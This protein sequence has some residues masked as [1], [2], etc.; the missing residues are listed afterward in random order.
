MVPHLLPDEAQL[1][2][3][4]SDLPLQLLSYVDEPQLY[5]ATLQVSFFNFTFFPS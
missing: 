5:I 4:I 2:A 3:L 1:E